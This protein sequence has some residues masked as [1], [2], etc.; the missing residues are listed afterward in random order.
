MKNLYAL[1][2]CLFFS[3]SAYPHSDSN[4]VCGITSFTADYVPNSCDGE[5]IE[6]EFDFD[7]TD[8]GASGFTISAPDGLQ[9][10]NIGDDYTYYSIAFCDEDVE[11]TITD[12][13]D[14]NCTETIILGPACCDC[15][16]S[17]PVLSAST[18]SGGLFDI[19]VEFD[20]YEGTC[21]NYN[22]YVTIEG[23]DYALDYVNGQGYYEATLIQAVGS[24]LTVML[25]NESP[26]NECYTILLDNPCFFTA[27]CMINTI[28]AF[29]DVSTCNGEIIDILFDIDAVDFG[30]NGFTVSDG[31][32]TETFDLNDDYEFT[33]ISEC[34]EDIE[35]TF[36]D[37]DDPDCYEIIT[38]TPDC[39]ACSVQDV[40]VNPTSC[41]NGTFDAFVDIFIES[42]SCIS[43]DWFLTVENTDYDLV[44][45]G[46]SFVA[47]NI[48]ATDSLVTAMV[49]TL[50]PSG[51]CFTVTFDNS[52]FVSASDCMITS[53]T[54]DYITD[55]CDG[56]IIQIDFDFNATDFGDNGFTIAAGG[57]TTSFNIGDPYIIYM[58]TLCTD[59]IAVVI[60]DNDDPNCT[61][62]VILNPACCDCEISDPVLE[63]TVCNNGLFDLHAEFEVLEGSCINYNWSV[64][65]EGTDYP[66][67]YN[68]GGY[69]EATDIQAV[70]S[71]LTILLCNESP[72]Q[73]CYTY[74]IENPCFDTTSNLDCMINSFTADYNVG[75]CEGE[76]I[77]IE[78]DFD[79]IDFGQNGFTVSAGGDTT[80]FNIGDPYMIYMITLCTD[81]IEVVITDNDDPNCTETVILNPACCDCE[82]SDPVIET[83]DCENE[84][85]DIFIDFFDTQGTCVNYEWFLTNDN[86]E[87][88]LTWNSSTQQYE[89]IDINTNATDSLVT[90]LLCNAS[91]LQE[92]FT[93]IIE[94]PCFDTT[95]NL[96]CM[97]NSFTANYISDSCEGEIVQIEFDFDATDFGTNGF[98]IT[99]P[100]GIQFYN[101]GDSYT[102]GLISY[103][104]DDVLLVI[105]DM[106]DPDCTASVILN[107]ACCDCEISD[108]IIETTDCENELFDVQVEFEVLEGT[109]VN[110]DWYVSIEGEDYDLE[111]NSA[112]YYEATDITAADSL[113]TVLLC[114]DSP[115]NECITLTIENPCFETENISGTAPVL[116]EEISLIYDGVGNITFSNS[117]LSTIKYMLWSID[118]RLIDNNILAPNGTEKLYTSQVPSGIYLLKFK[119][120]RGN[121]S[122]KKLV[123][124]H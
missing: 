40:F 6:I 113:L 16:I 23:T 14:P 123:L 3:F 76:I 52:C 66:L 118:G 20:L 62:T 50:A 74:T 89:A 121:I 42:G 91:P 43:Y 34:H 106:D 44:W 28:T 78:F 11:L 114:N 77:Q 104:V 90:I 117:S 31:T 8:F 18:C 17:D 57:D 86:E 1:I 10:Y 55:S 79:A 82:I 2:T 7:A 69:Y 103:C 56:E 9:T 122:V 60:T 97:I 112:G 19:Q 37:L 39:C 72:L 30:L 107:P 109:C 32:V 105:T 87:Y 108:P 83:S 96:D 49:C 70:D 33:V 95:S 24:V 26:L 38:I 46:S 68:N 47:S 36:T 61:E 115:L 65:I 54:A 100:E 4:L 22:W 25:C 48:I 124:V 67:N 73:E 59:D 13:D 80:S 84:T 94:N 63:T 120:E 35:L 116:L 85:F 75:S 27:D 119:N 12:I 71:L 98:E 111:Y 15:V 53:F 92:C 110:Y 99:G 88:D 58:I 101:L 102:Y 29:T 41:M 45:N 51:E 5:I 21:V 93:Y 81:D 64:T